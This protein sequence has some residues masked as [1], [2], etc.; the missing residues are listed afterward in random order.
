[1]YE[2]FFESSPQA[3]AVDMD[4]DMGFGHRHKAWRE[5]GG[6]QGHTRARGHAM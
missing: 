6:G 1:M 3:A 2:R 4:M 5:L